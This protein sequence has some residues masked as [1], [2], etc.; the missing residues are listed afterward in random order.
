MLVNIF[1]YTL[2]FLISFMVT[3]DIV[4]LC[5]TSIRLR[6]M[7]MCQENIYGDES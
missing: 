2:D 4:P 3:C 5:K 7:G 1:Y 6:I